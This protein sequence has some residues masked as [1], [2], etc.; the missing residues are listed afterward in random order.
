MTVQARRHERSRSPRAREPLAA[1]SPEVCA[2]E[3]RGLEILLW[4]RLHI[5]GRQALLPA[6]GAHGLAHVL[7]VH[8]SPSPRGSPRPRAVPPR[9][10][11]TRWPSISLLSAFTA[12]R[13]GIAA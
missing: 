5:A 4:T 7:A 1:L 10:Q 2:A 8:R 6:D 13:A 12:C 11:S 9:A 3:H